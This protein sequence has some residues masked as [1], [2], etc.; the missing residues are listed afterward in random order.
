MIHTNF[1]FALC[2]AIREIIFLKQKPIN[3]KCYFHFVKAI[4]SKMQSL[5][6]CKKKLRKLNI[7]VLRNIEILYFIKIDVYKNQCRKLFETLKKKNINEKFIKYHKKNWISKNPKNF[8]YNNF[9]DLVN[10][11]NK[12]NS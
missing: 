5:L 2:K 8:N 4:R 9:I 6:M 1:E 12:L 7:E 10:N 11:E 3:I